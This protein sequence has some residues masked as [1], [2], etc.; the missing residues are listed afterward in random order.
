MQQQNFIHF[1]KTGESNPGY[2]RQTE[3]P[4]IIGK[5]TKIR[6]QDDADNYNAKQVNYIIGRVPGFNIFITQA[7]FFEPPNRL[8][9]DEELTEAISDMC[10]W[11]VTEKLTG[12]K[13]MTKT[14]KIK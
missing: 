13:I 4:F 11:F 5:I 1:Q 3:P 6:R 9:T 2:L 12:N 7:G 14:F 8:I 10:D